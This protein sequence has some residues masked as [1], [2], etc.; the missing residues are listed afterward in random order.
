[1]LIFYMDLDTA[2]GRLSCSSDLSSSLR[3]HSQ[4]NVYHYLSLTGHLHCSLRS[5]SELLPPVPL[6]L[7]ERFNLFDMPATLWEQ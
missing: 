1:M 5:C 2:V 3:L 6:W 4:F 7:P